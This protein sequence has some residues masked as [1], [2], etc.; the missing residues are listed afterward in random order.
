M[1]NKL[2][3]DV[4]FQMGSVLRSDRLEKFQ[5]KKEFSNIL[6]KLIQV[7]HIQNV[8]EVY[9]NKNDFYKTLREYE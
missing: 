8:L 6:F 3:N 4:R 1:N 9:C 7:N 2:L 5:S